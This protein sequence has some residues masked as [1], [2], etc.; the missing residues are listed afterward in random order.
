MQRNDR[1]GA[2]APLVLLRHRRCRTS[3][4]L[5]PTTELAYQHSPAVHIEDLAG[6]E[7]GIFRAQKKDGPAI[8]SGLPARPSGIPERMRA[9]VLAS[10]S[11]GADISVSTHPG[12]TVL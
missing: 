6:D 10:F 2:S 7:A 12:A 3:G 5:A 8:S 11:A 1:V 9:L 4:T